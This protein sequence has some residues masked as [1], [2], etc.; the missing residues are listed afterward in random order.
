MICKFQLNYFLPV[1]TLWFINALIITFDHVLWFFKDGVYL[2][3][4]RNWGL[5]ANF[6]N[7]VSTRKSARDSTINFV[8]SASIENHRY[9]MQNRFSYNYYLNCFNKNLNNIEFFKGCS[10][11]P[12]KIINIVDNWS[13]F[14]KMEAWFE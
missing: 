2:Y 14:H 9:L 3:L 11:K 8:Q 7:L 13:I 6:C 1:R 12:A 4:F 5:L 10:Q